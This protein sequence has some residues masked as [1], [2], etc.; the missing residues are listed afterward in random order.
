MI[1]PAPSH[2]QRVLVLAPLGRDATIA[3]SILREAE[4]SA[5]AVVDQG[6]LVAAIDEGVGALI[7]TEEAILTGDS[8]P[9]A[10]WLRTQPAWSDLPVVVLTHHGGGLERNPA[11]A[12]LAGML[13]NV[14]FLERPFHPTTLV[15]VAATALRGRRRQYEAR[16]R[17]EEVQEGEARLRAALTLGRLGSWSLDLA[18][19]EL[20]SSA[21]HKAILGRSANDTLTL[22]ESKRCVHPDDRAVA[23]E[24]LS[25]AVATGAEYETEYRTVWPD[26]SVHWVETRARV[27]R[28]ATHRAGRLIGA[29]LDTTERK[30]VEQTLA[31]RVAERTAALTASERRFRALFDSAFQM[32]IL[33][34]L[35]GRILVA[36]RTALDMVGLATIDNR[37]LWEAQW[38]S[39]TRAEAERLRAEFPRA[40]AGAFVRREAVLALPGGETRTFDYSLKSVR[41]DKGAVAQV[42][43][44]ARDVT[45]LK[46]AEAALRQSQKLETIGHLTGG[47]AHDFN[48]LLMAVMANL[49]LLDRHVSDDPKLRKLVDGARQ[50]AERGAAL[51]QRLLAF[52]RR[53]D[54][55]PQAIDVHG[56]VVGMR[57]LLDQ[58]VGPTIPIELEGDTNGRLVLVDPNQ[59]ELAILN[60]AL[61][62]RDAM[63]DGGTL[64]ICFD[65]VEV[66]AGDRAGVEPASYLRLQMRD[67]GIGMDEATLKRAIEPFF[68]TKGI[69]KGTGLGLSMI[70]GL[71]VQSGGCLRLSSAVGRGTTAELLL[72]LTDTAAAIAHDHA[73]PRAMNAAGATILLV[74]DDP[75]IAMATTMML[76]DLGHHV[77]ERHSGPSALEVLRTT[78]T[79]DLLMTDLAMPGMTGLELALQARRL[80]PELPI[81]LATGYADLPGGAGIDLPRLTKPYGQNDVAAEVAKLL[82]QRAA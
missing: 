60:L 65:E 35:D 1:G 23:Q 17:L 11:A 32:A 82:T 72:P 63:P 31:A 45:E 28:D 66:R 67:T 13:G 33:L 2:S 41:D 40:V 73:E 9:L 51:T 6:R 3:C 29:S 30:Q 36:N 18:N 46:V 78:P 43:A 80:R 55:Q 62:A 4:I 69:G 53:Q 42:I 58:S 27:I 15:S 44:E 10:S 61:N 49:E 37:L 54:L 21:Q 38:W 74:D 76:E 48:N 24:T 56:L 22:E 47:V 59:L 71:A 16:A 14:T 68:S 79:V 75:L 52:A 19:G 8:Q 12:R 39:G 57:R 5:E 70:H 26:G 50:G 64:T 25:G 7:I 77:I 20:T 34:D 81:L